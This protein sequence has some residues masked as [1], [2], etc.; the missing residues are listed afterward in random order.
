MIIGVYDN[1]ERVEAHNTNIDLLLLGPCTRN[2]EC[3]MLTGRRY[4]HDSQERQTEQIRA[5]V[6]EEVLGARLRV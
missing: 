6:H 2:Q 5:Q 1:A 3:R 4:R